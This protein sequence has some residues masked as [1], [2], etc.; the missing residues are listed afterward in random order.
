MPIYQIDIKPSAQ[1][2]LGKLAKPLAVSIIKKI[3]GLAVNPYPSGIKKLSGMD[4]AYRVRTGDYRIIYRIFSDVLV[5]E[6]IKIGHRKSIY[7]N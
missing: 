1:K 5:V 2:A 4:N 6:V 3:N 7:K